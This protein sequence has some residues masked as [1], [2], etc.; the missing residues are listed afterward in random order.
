MI[1]KLNIENITVKGGQTIDDIVLFVINHWL[2]QDETCQNI[3]LAFGDTLIN[4]YDF[5][6][7]NSFSSH[8]AATSQSWTYVDNNADKV[9][10][11]Y[12]T[13]DRN[14]ATKVVQGKFGEKVISQSTLIQNLDPNESGDWLDTGHIS[15]YIQARS[16][17][18]TSRSFNNLKMT[19]HTV[20]KKSKNKSKIN[21][22]AEWFSKLPKDLKKYTPQLID[23]QHAAGC[24]TLEKLPLI[25]VS[26]IYLYGKQEARYWER[27]FINMSVLLNE[28]MDYRIPKNNFNYTRWV[29]NKTKNRLNEFTDDL[30]IL[31]A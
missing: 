5:T 9:F 10:S 13:L 7:I 29:K 1:R 14:I 11:G 25:P 24:Y 12:V 8:S 17:F 22:E 26:E 31:L 19:S 15:E 27:F 23:H 18:D 30:K 20:C 28:F 21:A 4:G 3:S 6:F 2:K 16:H